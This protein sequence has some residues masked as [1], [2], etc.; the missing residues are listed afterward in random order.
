MSPYNI[1]TF[2]QLKPLGYTKRLTLAQRCV[3]KNLLTP[4]FYVESIIQMSLSLTFLEFPACEIF[5]FVAQEASENS[6]GMRH[7]V[8]K[9]L[10]GL[11]YTPMEG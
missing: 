1:T 10:S 2:Q 11:L 6:E 4:T 9:T 3:E 5:V 7:I 8:V